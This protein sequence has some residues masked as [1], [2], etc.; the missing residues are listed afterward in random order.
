MPDRVLDVFVPSAAGPVVTITGQLRQASRARDRGG[1]CGP[2][3]LLRRR[4]G[5]GAP[6]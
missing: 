5:R 2:R 4:G 6:M 3:R 1:G